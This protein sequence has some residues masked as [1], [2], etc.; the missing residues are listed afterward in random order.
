MCPTNYLINANLT[1]NSIG[2]ATPIVLV[3]VEKNKFG[4][5]TLIIMLPCT[6]V[7]KH[8]NA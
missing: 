5:K 1:L 3:L 4:C 2:L 6:R 7:T 8:E